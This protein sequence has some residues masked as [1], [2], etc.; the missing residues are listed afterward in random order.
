[1]WTTLRTTIIGGIFFLIPLAFIAVVLGKAFQLS[2][3]IAHPIGALLPI[4]HIGGVALASV[5]GVLILVLVCFLAGLLARHARIADYSRRLDE[6]MTAV[7]PGYAIAKSMIG[8]LVQAQDA[9]GALKPV[10]VQMDDH[11]QL[12]FEVER[13]GNVV[14]VFLPGAPAAWSGSTVLV[15][16]N[17]VTPL[18]MAPHEVAQQLRVLGRGGAARLGPM[19]RERAPV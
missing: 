12:A 19:M 8:G 11:S 18:D 15:A 4:Q 10:L 3:K 16:P 13:D 5:L 6:M 1:M 7:L 9:M 2:M 14:V 17:R